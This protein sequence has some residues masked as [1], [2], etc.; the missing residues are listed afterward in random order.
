MD[1]MHELQEALEAA[2]GW[3]V[4]HRI[5]A[6]LT[7]LGLPAEATVAELSGGVKKRWA[8]AAKRLRGG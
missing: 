1:R 2:N 3:T 4:E 6:T 5:E 8:P 7:R